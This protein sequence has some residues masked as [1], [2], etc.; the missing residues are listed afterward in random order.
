MEGHCDS[1]FGKKSEWVV[2][3]ELPADK[4][5][6]ADAESKLAENDGKTLFYNSVDCE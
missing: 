6:F 5:P 4:I 2:D 1:R 3:F